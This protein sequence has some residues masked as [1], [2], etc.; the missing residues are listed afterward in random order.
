MDLSELQKQ[1]DVSNKLTQLF[2]QC[3]MKPLEGT[4]AKILEQVKALGVTASTDAGYLALTQ[5]PDNSG[6]V[7]SALAERLR[8]DNPLLFVADPSRDAVTSKA[9]L[10]RGSDGEIQKA[11]AQYISKHGFEQWANLPATKEEAKRKAIVPSVTMTKAEYMALP[12]KERSALCS[13]GADVITR[14]MARKG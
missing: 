2:Y 8:K 12:W 6:V 11:K 1:R 3:G 9:D 7:P 5:G 4:E 13:L 14:I 10:E